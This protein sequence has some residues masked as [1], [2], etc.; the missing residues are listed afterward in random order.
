MRK[1][2]ARMIET[3]NEVQIDKVAHGD[4]LFLFQKGVLISLNKQGILNNEQCLL[5][6]EKLEKQYIK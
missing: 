5:C 4:F 2:S 6:V 3:E 1:T